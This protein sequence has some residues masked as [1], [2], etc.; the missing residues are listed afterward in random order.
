MS[1]V[2]RDYIDV[3][4]NEKDRPLTNYP[5]KLAQYL[6]NRYKMQSGHKFLD[7]GCGRDEFFRQ[8]PSVWKRPWLILAT[9]LTRFLTSASFK[10][11]SKWVRFS[12]QIMLLSSAIKPIKDEVE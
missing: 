8:L 4:C 11:H 3:I 5:G 12:K 2:N 7:I 1:K 10:S 6:F 9:E